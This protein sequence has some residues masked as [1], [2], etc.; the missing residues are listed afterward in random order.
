MYLFFD[1]CGHFIL[2][3][4][5]TERI[6]IISICSAIRH[7]THQDATALLSFTDQR[8]QIATSWN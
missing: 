6:V 8:T 7:P 2:I 4:Q 5:L 3:F 1:H